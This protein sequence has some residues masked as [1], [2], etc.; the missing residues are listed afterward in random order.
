MGTDEAEA[1]AEMED[2]AGMRSAGS[3][4]SCCRSSKRRKAHSSELPAKFRKPPRQ[5]HSRGKQASKTPDEWLGRQNVFHFIHRLLHLH[6]DFGCFL[7]LHVFSRPQGFAG[8]VNFNVGHY[9]CSFK[10]TSAPRW[11]RG[12]RQHENIAMANAEGTA[13]K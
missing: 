8:R 10:R 3:I 12:G 1:E 11:I 4:G 9:P 5:R 2:V 13:A 6:D 7:Q